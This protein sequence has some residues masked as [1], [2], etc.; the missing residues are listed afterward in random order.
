[1]FLLNVKKKMQQT[2]EGDV[3]GSCEANSCVLWRA[4]ME[5][6]GMRGASLLGP[7]YPALKAGT[8][9]TGTL[10]CKVAAVCDSGQKPRVNR[11]LTYSSNHN[12]TK[13]TLRSRW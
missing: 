4:K 3:E 5:G 9:P 12:T 13:E 2:G 10:D 8:S 1:M 7:P 11:Y 6:R